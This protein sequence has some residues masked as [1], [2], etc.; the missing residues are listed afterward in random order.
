MAFAMMV[1][2]GFT[3]PLEG[4]KLPSSLPSRIPASGRTRSLLGGLR[5]EQVHLDRAIGRHDGRQL[6]HAR[7]PSI[8]PAGTD[9]VALAVE[10]SIFARMRS[11]RTSR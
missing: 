7:Q 10:P 8:G 4:K 11:V 3:A 9:L 1:R 2:A 5:A 6:L